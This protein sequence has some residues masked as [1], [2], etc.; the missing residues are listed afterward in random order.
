MPQL[1]TEEEL[2]ALD[3]KY[4]RTALVYSRQTGADS[5]PLWA[6]VLRKP[7]RA[8]YKM[9][10]SQANDPGSKADSQEV[11]V[12][13]LI[14]WPSLDATG[15]DALLDD[16]PGIPEA[17]GDALLDLTGAAGKADAK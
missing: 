8:E 9:W 15:I 16:W 4:R 10:R 2:S 1:P 3:E 6:V 7:Q 5:K 11:L 12:R 13:K 17:C 14:V